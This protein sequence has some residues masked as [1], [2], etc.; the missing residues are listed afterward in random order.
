MND[1]I[2]ILFIVQTVFLIGMCLLLALL[3]LNLS[4]KLMWFTIQG[5][6]VAELEL[7]E[8]QIELERAKAAADEQR[9]LAEERK[10]EL[11][12]ARLERGLPPG[13]RV[14]DRTVAVRG[15]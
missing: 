9:A 6:S 7:Q 4:R 8:K 5:R 11:Q 3:V 14:P 13:A 10:A 2:V 12:M 1:P 15:A